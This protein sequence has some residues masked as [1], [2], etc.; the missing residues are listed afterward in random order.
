MSE[1]GKSQGSGSHAR[2]RPAGSAVLFDFDGTLFFGTARLNGWCFEQALRDMGKPLPTREMLERSVG[3]T[4]PDIARLML[5]GGDPGETAL[6]T[7][8]VS[9]RVPD[10]IR[11]FVRPDPA[12]KDMLA[13]LRPQARL[14]VCS[15]GTR[16][17]L[18]LML[19]ALELTPLLDAVWPWQE[20][21]TKAAAIPE[22][23]RRLEA[24]RVVFVGDRLE[25]VLCAREAGVPVVG[26][27]NAAFPQEVNGADAV[28]ETPSQMLRAVRRLLALCPS[29]EARTI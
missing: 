15:N 10:Y 4:F 7:Q 8:L 18:S 28:V 27:R 11:Q 25:D 12:V 9:Q 14:A 6:F 5:G 23:R 22:L 20:G 26:I 16:S 21:Y 3:M 2:P 1:N 13:A 19:D 17:Y 24:Q 29:P